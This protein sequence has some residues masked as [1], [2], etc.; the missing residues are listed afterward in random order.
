MIRVIPKNSKYKNNFFKFLSVLDILIIAVALMVISALS[1]SNLSTKWYIVG[2]LIISTIVALTQVDGDRIYQIIFGF[3]LHAISKKKFS[4]EKSDM[5]MMQSVQKIENNLLVYDRMYSKVI[6]LSPIPFVL[7][8]EDEQD[9]LIRRLSVC[10]ASLADIEHSEIHIVKLS[11]PISYKK[12]IEENSINKV[13]VLTKYFK[14]GQ[15]SQEEY[16]LRMNILNQNT[17]LYNFIE[18]NKNPTEFFFFQIIAD[19]NTQAEEI[20]LQVANEISALD[21]DCKILN[22]EELGIFVKNAWTPFYDE[23]DLLSSEEH[24]FLNNGYTKE[25]IYQYLMPSNIDIKFNKCIIDDVIMSNMSISDYPV[26]VGNSWGYEIFHIPNSRVTMKIK[27]RPRDRAMK[28]IDKSIK[29]LKV[30]YMQEQDE[31]VKMGIE[32]HINSLTESLKQLQLGNDN[33]YDVS[34]CVTMYEKD[35]RMPERKRAKKRIANENFRTSY[36]YGETSKWIISNNLTRQ[37]IGRSIGIPA[38]TLAAVFPFISFS[39]ND[40]KGV[41]IGSAN[42]EPCLIDIF[43]RDNKGRVNGNAFVIGQSGSGKSYFSKLLLS[44]NTASN[45]KIIIFDPEREYVKFARNLCGNS[46]DVS[47]ASGGRIN[48]FE[49]MKELEDE[50]D[51]EFIISMFYPHL[52]FLESFF[53]VVLPKLPDDVFEYLNSLIIDMYQKKGIDENTDFSKLTSK[54][55]PIFD[56]LYELIE[57]RIN[58]TKYEFEL[59]QLR[60]LRNYIIK[61]ARDGRYANLWNG[62]TTMKIDANFINFDFRSMLITENKTLANAQML[63]ILRFCNLEIIKNKELNDKFGIDRR[64]IIFIDEAHVYFNK[65]MQTALNFFSQ[66]ARRIRKYHGNIMFTTQNIGDFISSSDIADKT[67]AIINAC[68][69]S[70]I[71]GLSAGALNDVIELYKNTPYP[72]N[73]NE[74]DYIGNAER[75]QMFAV[76]SPQRRVGVEIIAP[77]YLA[78]LFGEK[79]A[80]PIESDENNVEKN[81]V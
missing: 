7:K 51:E 57:D 39:I 76:I 17:N 10:F 2:T 5:H 13:E 47:N 29:G 24:D 4:K 35:I 77:P 45:T 40:P 42:E 55:Y 66:M 54:E 61:F 14:S 68:Q 70:F 49:V 37:S 28:D 62:C 27:L 8:S 48:P 16:E 64:I 44:Q 80:K 20:A 30:R 19:Y 46:I 58:T 32:I 74:M 53:R 63:L 25:E 23:K 73:N 56:D 12:I 26:E 78:E 36:N 9:R 1:L 21:I 67:K 72:L 34:L 18:S 52:Q 3:I 59:P 75:G 33:L 81:V 11:R 69:Y 15:M 6:E 79:V 60:L 71:F 22:N 65:E 43:H 41:L 50:D 31:S 38:T